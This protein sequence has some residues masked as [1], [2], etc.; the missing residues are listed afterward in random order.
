MYQVIQ[1]GSAGVGGYH[2]WPTSFTE[3]VQTMI[4]IPT[5]YIATYL[6]KQYCFWIMG[7]WDINVRYYY[8]RTTTAPDWIA[9]TSDNGIFYYPQFV[10]PLSFKLIPYITL[11]KSRRD[12]TSHILAR[13]ALQGVV[14]PLVHQTMRFSIMV[15][16]CPPPCHLNWFHTSLLTNQEGRQLV[17]Y[18]LI[19]HYRG[20]FPPC[21]TLHT[22][23]I[24][25]S[26]K[27][28]AGMTYHPLGCQ[29]PFPCVSVP[30]Y[31]SAITSGVHT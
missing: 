2:V 7:V 23:L 30:C 27:N 25:I 24:L 29:Y 9:S 26:I 8:V 6:K 18:W 15:N 4:G 21:M 22:H 20:L 11:N 28:M 12:A 5:Q 14:L 13:I 17:T 3:A 1:I 10:V 19:S 16:V 31:L